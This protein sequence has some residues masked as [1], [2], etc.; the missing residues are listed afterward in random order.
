[1][2]KPFLCWSEALQA[3]HSGAQVDFLP[4][5]IEAGGLQSVE[6]IEQVIYEAR[7]APVSLGPLRPVVGHKV[8]GDGDCRHPLTLRHQVRINAVPITLVRYHLPKRSERYRRVA[9]L[10]DHL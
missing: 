7:H 3:R 10:V 6:T 4:L 1:M 2:I 8:A 5:R 9:R